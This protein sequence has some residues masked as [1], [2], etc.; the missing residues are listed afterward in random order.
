LVVD[1]TPDSQAAK[2]LVVA[3]LQAVSP[4]L[5]LRVVPQAALGAASGVRP[6]SQLALLA[7]AAPSPDVAALVQRALGQDGRVSV[8]CPPQGGDLA[9]V[10]AWDGVAERADRGLRPGEKAE[11]WLPM[12]SLE[13]SGLAGLVIPR[14]RVPQL[15][16]G[17]VPAIVAEDGAVVQGKMRGDGQ[18]LVMGIPLDFESDSPVFHPVFPHL[19]AGVICQGQA[20]Q[21]EGG[22]AVGETPRI[23][24]LFGI[25]D[26][27]G[28]VV[29]PDGKR[30]PFAQASDRVFLDRPGIWR[31]VGAAGELG[32][33]VN[34][35][36]PP[37]APSPPRDEWQARHPGL[38][39]AWTSETTDLSDPGLYVRSGQRE[40]AY[41]ASSVMA[42]MLL[43]GLI[44][45]AVLRV[46]GARH[47]RRTAD[48]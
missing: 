38:E 9:G 33:A 34:S 26:C 36:R 28:N 18:L 11:D 13:L 45:E 17:A 16:D 19:V 30:R 47:G 1:E 22:H 43:V 5:R 35:A 32:V 25:A 4:S 21:G 3:A 2:A 10:F 31:L 15:G 23:A 44:G 42:V 12:S 48:A 46:L 14:L 27:R 37:D 41:D 20:K 6:P 40:R 39:A 29:S 24:D 7:L 8:F